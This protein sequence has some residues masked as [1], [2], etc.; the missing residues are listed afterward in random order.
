M[1]DALGCR[2]EPE[3]Y[4]RAAPTDDD[5]QFLLELESELE[6][7]LDETRIDFEL[8]I[9]K[10]YPG[11]ALFVRDGYTGSRVY[12]VDDMPLIADPTGC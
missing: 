5:L 1:C 12:R 11:Q 7:R 8:E 6:R 9:R 4:R 10:H 3:A 2:V